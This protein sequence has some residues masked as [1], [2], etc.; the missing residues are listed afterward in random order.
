MK[1]PALPVK[2]KQP[3]PCNPEPA[4]RHSQTAGATWASWRPARL[5]ATWPDHARPGYRAVWILVDPVTLTNRHTRQRSIPRKWAAYGKWPRQTEARSSLSANAV[6]R[7]ER[8]T[9]A[10]MGGRYTSFVSRRSRQGSSTPRTKCND[11]ALALVALSD[12]PV[13]ASTRSTPLPA[14][15]S[16]VECDVHPISPFRRTSAAFRHARKP[17]DRSRTWSER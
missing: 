9:K 11:D 15:F 5:P 13:H 8:G 6:L 12:D 14:L 1:A 4:Q 10:G 17:Q 2:Q 3:F 7:P 16:T